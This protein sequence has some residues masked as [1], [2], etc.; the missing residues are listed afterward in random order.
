MGT[1]SKILFCRR[2]RP[3]ER[4]ERFV[5][6]YQQYDG[7]LG[8]V[9]LKLAQ[10]LKTIDYNRNG[11]FDHERTQI[12][13]VAN[14]FGCMVAQFIAQEKTEVGQLYIE[15]ANSSLDCEYNYTV[16][17]CA[18]KGTC[19]RIDCDVEEDAHNPELTVDEFYDVCKN[20]HEE[21]DE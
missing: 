13:K 20:A 1:H 11:F 10:F 6:I 7:D 16:I 14:G 15:S 18:E 2:R 12:G 9:G 3:E 5:V 17:D 4:V 8:G 19:V 21:Y